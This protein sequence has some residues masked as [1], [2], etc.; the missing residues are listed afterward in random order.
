MG[1]TSLGLRKKPQPQTESSEADTQENKVLFI[2]ENVEIKIIGL[3]T[4]GVKNDLWHEL[5]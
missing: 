3:M 2:H 4:F 5:H 1:Y